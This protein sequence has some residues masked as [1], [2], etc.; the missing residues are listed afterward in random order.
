MHA[1]LC[2]S[3]PLLHDLRGLYVVSE[4]NNRLFDE[5]TVAVPG[6]PSSSSS[7]SSITS[8]FLPRN[9]AEGIDGVKPPSCLLAILLLSLEPDEASGNC[10]LRLLAV[11]TVRRDVLAAAAVLVG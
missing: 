4:A 5:R 3:S 1:C 10:I 6:V 2:K 7:S 9:D 11:V 8:A